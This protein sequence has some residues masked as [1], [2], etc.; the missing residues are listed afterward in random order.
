MTMSDQTEQADR[1]RALINAMLTKVNG[2]VEGL[3]K[4]LFS[5]IFLTRIF[6]SP[7]N[8]QENYVIPAGSATTSPE[9]IL[10]EMIALGFTTA[11]HVLQSANEY[12]EILDI[13]SDNVAAI[14]SSMKFL[15]VA[16]TLKSQTDGALH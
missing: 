11:Q 2:N 12:Q 15:I 7:E 16:D 13:E 4:C 8:I 5:S 6:I 14:I 10:E 3:I 9:D 1:E